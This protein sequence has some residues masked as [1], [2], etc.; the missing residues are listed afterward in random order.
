MSWGLSKKGFYRPNQNEIKAMLDQRTKDSFGA[1][2]NINYKSPNGILN[3]IWSWFFAKLWEMAEKVYHS[4]HPSQAEGVQLDYLTVFF[5]TSRIR[6]QYSEGILKFTGTPFYTIPYGRLFER[7]DGVQFVLLTPVTLDAAGIGYGDVTS[8]DTG[9]DTNSS[10]NTITIQVEP[11]SDITGVTNE[12]ETTGGAEEE[13]DVELRKRLTN[14]FAALGSGTVN[15]ILAD[16]LEVPAVRAVR[17]K[18]NEKGVTVDGLPPH[19]IAVY[20]YGG[21]DNDIANALMENYTGIQFFGSTSVTVKDISGHD[22]IIAFSKATTVPIYFDLKLSSNN[23]FSAGGI[24]D[25]KDAIV[26]VV[27]GTDTR[28]VVHN[29]LNMGEP[30]VYAR[31]ISAI[32]GVQGV[33]NVQL[34]M[35]DTTPPTSTADITI[36]DMEVASVDVADI[37]VTLV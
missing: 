32:M 3:G 1:N 37:G 16:L 30:V 24:N 4:S 11:D 28:G 8:L 21:D 9:I 27:G 14:S 36:N 15:S 17:V 19:S 6:P 5:G 7:Q 12:N 2:V 29:G 23:T 22:H 33:T 25:V 35:G 31:V 13:G 18:V 34:T 10:V 26:S 20:T